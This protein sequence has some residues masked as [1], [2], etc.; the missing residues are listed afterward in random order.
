MKTSEKIL[1]TVATLTF[2]PAILTFAWFTM[3]M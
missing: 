3:F 1:L 2:W